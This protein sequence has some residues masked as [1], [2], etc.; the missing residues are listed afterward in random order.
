M[1]LVVLKRQAWKLIPVLKVILRKNNHIY[2][3][4][5]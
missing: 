1:R 5:G 4:C 2:G 3:R